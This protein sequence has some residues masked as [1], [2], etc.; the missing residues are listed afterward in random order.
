M[1]LFPCLQVIALLSRLRMLFLDDCKRLQSLPK[2]SL[3]DEDKNYGPRSR[4]NYY[5]SAE[6]VDPS[7]FHASCDNN[8]PTVSCLNCPNLSVNKQGNYLV[9]KILNSY[10]ELRKKFWLTPEAVFE[11][12]GAGSKIPSGLVQPGSGGMILEGPW[13]GVAICAVIS[14]NYV[15]D[16][17]EAEY[18][19]TAHIHLGEKDVEIPV[20]INYLMAESETQ[21]VFYLT[22]ADDI[23]RTVGS[24]QSSNF[25]VSFSVEPGQ[26]H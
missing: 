20:P 9:E 19:V 5:V 13:I 26:S 4:F 6:G 7:K 8:R 22:V 23:Q 18:M 10:L 17:M 24:S 14:V 12:V 3:V 21:L 11:I 15:D 1:N 2:L 25:D 16:Y